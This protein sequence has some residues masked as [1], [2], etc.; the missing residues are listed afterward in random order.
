MI[1][2]NKLAND[3]KFLG[4]KVLNF[5]AIHFIFILFNDDKRQAG[6]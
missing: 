1:Y 6:A 4:N 2:F 3:V 5:K